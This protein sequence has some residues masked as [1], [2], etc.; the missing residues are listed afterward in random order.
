MAL[1]RPPTHVRSLGRP[2]LLSSGQAPLSVWTIAARALRRHRALALAQGA[3]LAVAL[4]VPLCLRLV[5]DGA[6]QAGY[7]SLL[8]AGSGVVGI[9]EPR[10]ANPD[11]FAGIQPRTA[12]LVN[13]QFG[14]ALKLLSTSALTVA[15]P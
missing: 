8:A 2:R 14:S 10:M 11:A 15:F 9:E 6:A 3:A 12:Q 7:Q 5:A 13:G 4:A 1:Q